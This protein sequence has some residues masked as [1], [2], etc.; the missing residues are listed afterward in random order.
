MDIREWVGKLTGQST[1]PCDYIK[2]APIASSFP[3]TGIGHSQLNELL[4]AFH[5]DRT[6][7]GFFEYV[8]GGQAVPD[9]EAFKERINAF[10]IKAILKYGNVK[11]AYKQLSLLERSQIEKELGDIDRDQKKSEYMS[12]HDPLVAIRDIAAKDTYYLGY[13][14]ES[15]L[16]QQKVDNLR[17]IGEFNH[18]CYLDYDHMD[19]YVATSMRERCDF[20]NV[21][22][23]LRE[24][25]GRPEIKELKLRYFDPT[26]AYCR[27]RLDKS[28]SE[29]LMLKRARCSIYMVGEDDTLGKDSELAATLA[30]GKPVIAYVPRLT[31]YDKF[32][33]EIAEP[34][35][36]DCYAGQNPVDVAMKFLRL[37]N[38]ESP[39][40]DKRVRE[41]IDR[42]TQPS[43]DDVLKLVFDSANA[44][45][46]KRAKTLLKTHPLGLQV[47]LQTGV[48]NGV[49][50]A[51][52]VSQCAELLRGVLLNGLEFDLNEW[53]E[54]N[55][56]IHLREKKTGSVYRVVTKDAHLTN[57]FWNFY[58]KVR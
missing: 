10:R 35:L 2:D 57:S 27:H 8:F 46:E 30:Q 14:T 28:L 12:R 31:D 26:Q 19:V 22:R 25:F 7:K 13:V 53:T 17:Q 47:N 40:E 6:E 41:W 58:L 55:G 49:L 56:A 45:Y 1:E 38:R 50:V 9:F 54:E 37:Y 48:A 32:K 3:S 36:K 39:W 11:F 15:D 16:D 52:D 44:L 33:S 23:F 20:W 34:L 21:N 43:F 4:L 5:L 51:R 29:A 24:L 18:H 42:T